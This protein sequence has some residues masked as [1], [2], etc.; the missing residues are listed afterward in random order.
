MGEN[1]DY[2]EMLKNSLEQNRKLLENLQINDESKKN[3]K[4][5]ITQVKKRNKITWKSNSKTR[6]TKSKRTKS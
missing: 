4:K 6:R 1:M 2:L 5:Q 3:N